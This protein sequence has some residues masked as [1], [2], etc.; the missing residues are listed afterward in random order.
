LALPLLAPCYTSG[1]LNGPYSIAFPGRLLLRFSRSP[2][3]EPLGIKDFFRRQGHDEVVGSKVLVCSLHPKFAELL[4]VDSN[5]YGQF[6][7]TPTATTFA[8][9]QELC[10]AI[11]K[12]YDIVHLFCDASPEG[13]ITDGGGATTTGTT[14]IQACCDSGVKLLWVASENKPE[15][16]IKGFK[17][18]GKPLNLVMTIN[19]QGTKFSV[20]LERLLSKMSAGETMPVAWVAVSPQS[21]NDPRQKD[22]PACIFAAGRGRVKL[23]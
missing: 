15:A 22:S 6:Y 3:E 17:A 20:F 11:A 10:G 18:N 12:G 14:L 19:R 23:R 7:P 16:Y 9:V 5:S 4:S 2:W 1:P 21:P 8:S 13:I